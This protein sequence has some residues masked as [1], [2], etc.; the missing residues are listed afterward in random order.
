MKQKV[1][2]ARAFVSGAEVF[3]MDEPTSEL[4]EQSEKEVLAHLHRLSER[5]GKTV[6][7]VHHGLGLVAELASEVCVVNHGRIR[8]VTTENAHS[9]IDSAA[10][11]SKS[12]E[13]RTHD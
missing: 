8:T 3:I 4:D 7:L 2:V 12:R 11:I 13:D 1:L 6:L 10:F 9:L 5:E